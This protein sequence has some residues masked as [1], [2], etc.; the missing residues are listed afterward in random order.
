MRGR[1]VRGAQLGQ[2]LREPLHLRRG[3]GRAAR[4]EFAK[5]RL[6][7]RQPAAQPS[8]LGLQ[9]H[10]LLTYERL[11]GRGRR[12]EFHPVNLYQI[13][14]G[15]VARVGLQARQR[16]LHLALEIPH[17]AVC[18]SDPELITLVL[19]NLVGNS[20]KYSSSGTVQIAAHLVDAPRR[21]VGWLLSVSDQGPGIPPQHL[22]DIFDLFQRAQTHGRQGM[23]LAIAS[24]AARLLGAELTADSKVGVGSTFRLMLPT[25]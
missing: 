2:G 16:G 20:I 7:V 11:R 6:Q 13:A 24:E 3:G 25:S 4:G 22:Q 14:A 10:R 12:S 21:G 23:G 15:V 1:L 8:H 18:D 19:Q 5:L 17:D 9:M